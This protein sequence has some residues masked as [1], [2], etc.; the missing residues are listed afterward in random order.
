MATSRSSSNSTTEAPGGPDDF[1]FASFVAAPLQALTAAMAVA[2]TTRKSFTT[3]VGTIESLQRS[4]QQLEAIL[5]R[6]ES[7]VSLVEAPA[8]ALA[9]EMDRV[10][11]RIHDIGD[12]LDGPVDSLL[13]GLQRMGAAFERANLEQLPEVLD[14]LTGQLRT[15]ANVFTEVPRRLGP[16]GELL[17]SPATGLLNA[18][19]PGPSTGPRRKAES[20]APTSVPPKRKPKATKTSGRK[21]AAAGR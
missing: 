7:V 12:A 3:L 2:D 11:R 14:L 10:A 17:T 20:P 13:P 16:V 5:G 8:R 9:P 21:P 15:M 1:D 4:A 19:L 6:V 18:L